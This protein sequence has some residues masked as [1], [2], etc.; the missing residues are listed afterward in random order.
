[1]C[2]HSQLFHSLTNI[3]FSLPFFRFLSAY[4]FWLKI[5]V[6]LYMHWA[7]GVDEES[8]RK[9]IVGIICWP[10]ITEAVSPDKFAIVYSPRELPQHINLST[11]MFECLPVRMAVVHV[12]LPDKPIYHMM[13]S[14]IALSMRGLSSRLKF[15]CGDS[16]EIQYHLHGYG[17]PVDQIPITDTG[18]IKTKNLLQW[19]RVRKFLESNS[20]NGV[21]SSD[22][23]S[24]G[25]SA[26]HLA[27]DCPNMNDVIFRG[28]HA[29]LSH[30]GNAMF[31][32]L[33]ESKHEEHNKAT[34]TDAKVQLTWDIIGEVETKNG[35]FLVWDKNGCWREMTNRN[36]IRTKVAGALKD[37][38][39]RLK[40]RQNLI[41]NHSST[42]EFEGQ[43]NDN[44][45]RKVA[46][47]CCR[48]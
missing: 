2:M 44:K 11:R 28:K 27:I 40:A 34:T 20:S 3:T 33:I 4:V 23:E 30:P 42:Y 32:G 1:M 43:Y 36:Q 12:C 24:S 6:T 21:T 10:S 31:R 16:V 35:R 29:C 48:G 15:H 19:I 22:S 5:R 18:N 37:H 9:G 13:R 41:T 45:K 14:G 7:L 17:I 25:N 26:M 8:Q 47:N 38:K 39:R 46:A